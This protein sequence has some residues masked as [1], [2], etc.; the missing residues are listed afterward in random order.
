M[1]KSILYPVVG[2]AALIAAF[3]YYYVTLPAI[4]IHSSGFWF[5]LLGAIVVVMVICLLRRAGKEIFTSGVTSM[6]FS[7]KDFP[8]VKWLGILFLVLLAAYGIGTLLSSPVIN[9]KKYQQLMT[10]EARNFAEDIAEADYRSIPLLDKDSAALLGDRKMGSLVDMVSQFEVADDYT[11][12]NY[13]NVAVRVTPL[14][15]ASPVKWLTNQRNGIPAYIRIDMTTQDTECV[16]LEEGIRYSKSEYFNRNLYRHLRFHF[17]TYIFGDQLF[18]EIDDDGVPYW[19]CP[20]KKF[21]IGLFGGET[22]G[23]VVLVNA[24][25]GECTDYAVEDVPT[26]ID[27]VYSAELLMQLYDYHGMYQHGFFNSILGQ[28]DCLV[29]TDGYNYLAIDDDVWVYTGITSVN[30]DQSNVGF[31]LMNQR[32]METRYYEV[33]GATEL[34]AM[35]SAQGQVQNLG[36]RASFPLLLNIADEPTYFMAL[37]DDAGLVKKYAMVNVQKYQWVAIGDTIEECEKDYKDLLS[38]NGI[39]SPSAGEK[40]EISGI[41]ELIAPVVIEGST[42]YYIGITGSDE[43]FD[44]EVSDEGLYEIVRYKEGD[45]ISLVYEENYG[46]NPVSEIKE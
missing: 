44:V 32:T 34:S 19:V 5:F 46:L 23:R 37:K 21:N 33:E 15:Y 20:V 16:M 26:W 7:L 4:N 3:I 27:K 2:L 14:V 8:A 18:F 41:I 10:V 42:H 17:P 35:S 43:L 6:Q 13:N 40:H 36:Y 1:K 29:T 31:V 30:G 25:T 28:R 11:Q 38:T 12:I 45:R 24:V 22:V 9:A 39:V